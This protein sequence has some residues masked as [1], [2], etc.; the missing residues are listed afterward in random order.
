[1]CS[2]PDKALGIQTMEEMWSLL[3]ETHPDRETGLARE[4]GE[5]HTVGD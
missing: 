1:M 2:I 4:K 5:C 3:L